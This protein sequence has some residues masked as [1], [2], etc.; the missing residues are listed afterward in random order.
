MRWKV[1][2]LARAI[3]AAARQPGLPIPSSLDFTSSPAVG[4]TAS[5]DGRQVRVGGPRLLEETGLAEMGQVRP[6]HDDGATV[7][8]VVVDG[9]VI[10]ALKLADAVRPESREAVDALHRLGMQVAMINR[11]CRTRRTCGVR[12]TRHRPLLR[13]GP[14]R[15][16]VGE[17]Q[18][19]AIRGAEGRHGR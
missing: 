7:L 16:Q 11:R 12:G 17:G 8:H 14:P 6:W 1:N 18:R 3:V 10:G 4:V 15:R 2:G 13:P 5:V 19:T 9:D